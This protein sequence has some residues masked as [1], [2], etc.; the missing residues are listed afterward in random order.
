MEF[1]YTSNEDCHTATGL[2]VVV[3]V[4]RAFSTAAYAFRIGADSIILV[5]GIEEALI[6]KT[7]IPGA[8][9]MGE[10]GGLPPEGF[11]FGNS[12][13]DVV[14]QDLRGRRLIQRTG[15]GTQG[16]V[17]S[18]N[19]EILFAASFV[20]AGATVRAVQR[21]KPGKITFVITGGDIED[22]DRSCAEYIEMLL[23]GHNPD[24]APYLDRVRNAAELGRMP[25]E[26]FPNIK[27]DIDFC[28]RLDS[29]LFAMPITHEN[30]RLVMRPLKLELEP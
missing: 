4:I 21:L 15:A 26:I 14:R 30:G 9:V 17:R 24:P 8:L 23:K 7:Q 18:V 19:A 25:V 3:D 27:S 16:A 28:T 29:C 12:P 22:E 2:V 6:L 5:G 13:T 20:V 1:C 11:D 10:V